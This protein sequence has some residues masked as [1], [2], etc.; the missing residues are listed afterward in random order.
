MRSR[1]GDR[2]IEA[3]QSRWSARGYQAIPV[4]S[5]APASPG[6]GQPADYR[7]TA[8]LEMNVLICRRQGV[9][10]SWGMVFARV[11]VESLEFVGVNGAQHSRRE[12]PLEQAAD[13]TS[14]IPGGGD[15]DQRRAA[16]RRDRER[17]NRA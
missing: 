16:S 11:G 10:A 3:R 1:L 13:A 5:T 9:A 4:P 2:M 14:A 8:A 7:Y 6:Y 12:H 15:P 17:G